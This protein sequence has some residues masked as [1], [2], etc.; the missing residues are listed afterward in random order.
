M[1]NIQVAQEDRINLSNPLLDCVVL[2]IVNLYRFCS[3][4]SNCLLQ[5]CDRLCI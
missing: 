4:V 2:S 3:R 5:Y 1:K